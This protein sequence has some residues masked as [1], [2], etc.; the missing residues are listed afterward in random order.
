MGSL[1]E[2]RKRIEKAN[3]PL[4]KLLHLVCFGTDCK[5]EYLVHNLKCF[6]GFSQ[7]VDIYG[8]KMRLEELPVS[9][10]RQLA[11]L[12]TLPGEITHRSRLIDSIVE[13]L[14]N[15]T[16][17]TVGDKSSRT[18]QS[19]SQTNRRSIETTSP[20][21]SSQ[22]TSKST[23]KRE[24]FVESSLTESDDEEERM[25]KRRKKNDHDSDYEEDENS[26][27]SESSEQSSNQK[28]RLAISEILKVIDRN[29]Y[30]DRARVRHLLMSVFKE[31]TDSN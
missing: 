13:F 21:N 12:L 2:V 29:G 17:K 5:S 8:K 28:D 10:L 11:D 30:N 25:N 6:D 27:T 9:E 3:K 31:F 20:R 18:R 23:K 4:L 22:A 7:D 15:P 26:S 1:V 14:R 24:I 16:S 19:L